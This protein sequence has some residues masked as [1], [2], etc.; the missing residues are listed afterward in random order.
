MG[1]SLW[2]TWREGDPPEAHGAQILEE[3]LR[4]GTGSSRAWGAALGL[5]SSSPSVWPFGGRL[6]QVEGFVPPLS[7]LQAEISL[8]IPLGEVFW[9]IS[10]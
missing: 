2:G 6:L 3:G 8:E 9:S 7:W 4:Q 5:L 10:D 1:S